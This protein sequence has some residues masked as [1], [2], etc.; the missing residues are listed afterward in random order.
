MVAK[1]RILPRNTPNI[2]FFSKMATANFR[3]A[4]LKGWKETAHFPGQPTS[5]A[6]LYLFI[7]AYPE[8]HYTRSLDRRRIVTALCRQGDRTLV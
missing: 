4:V 5:T 3:P 1:D 8:L 7:Y 6:S 2:L